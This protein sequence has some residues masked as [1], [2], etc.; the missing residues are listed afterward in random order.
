[1]KVGF[2]FQHRGLCLNRD[3]QVYVG[4]PVSMEVYVACRSAD[5]LIFPCPYGGMCLFLCAGLPRFSLSACKLLTS[6]K[7]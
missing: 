7:L 5:L 4:F 3:I 1:M 2:L 6:V